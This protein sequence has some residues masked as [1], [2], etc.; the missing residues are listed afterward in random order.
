MGITRR[1]DFIYYLEKAFALR[2]RA[3]LQQQS[4]MLLYSYRKN[5]FN[6]RNGLQ[7]EVFIIKIVYWNN[8]QELQLA[9]LRRA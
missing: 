2:F 6:I 1:Q 9:E 8:L 7:L 5:I 4:M 3:K